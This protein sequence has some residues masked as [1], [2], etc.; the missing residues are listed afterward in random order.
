MDVAKLRV[1]SLSLLTQ[2]RLSNIKK[3]KLLGQ[4]AEKKNAYETFLA[5]LEYMRN[6]PFEEQKHFGFTDPHYES[7]AEEYYRE[8]LMFLEKHD[9]LNYVHDNF[10]N[11]ENLVRKAETYDKEREEIEINNKLR[12]SIPEPFNPQENKPNIVQSEQGKGI[13]LSHLLEK[14]LEENKQDVRVK[15]SD[16]MKSHIGFLICCIGDKDVSNFTQSDL[17]DYKEKL[18]EK[19]KGY[20]DQD[21]LISPVTKNDHLESCKRLFDFAIGSYNDKLPNYFSNPTIRYKETSA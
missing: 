2:Q 15:T 14:Y 3:A 12:H 11:V 17:R 16:K 18:N 9:L 8:Q 21:V 10:S 20:K 19:T 5:H 7:N 13:L 1:Q 6:A 4:M